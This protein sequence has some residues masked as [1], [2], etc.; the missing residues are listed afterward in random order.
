MTNV[1][2]A[3]ALALTWFIAAGCSSSAGMSDESKPPMVSSTQP[4]QS[5][6]TL[7]HAQNPPVAIERVSVTLNWS[8]GGGGYIQADPALLACDMPQAGV[9]S[10][11]FPKGVSVRL[12]AEPIDGADFLG[13]GGDCAMAGSST[14]CQLTIEGT[15]AIDVIFR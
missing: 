7:A 9:Q 11:T 5:T 4:I 15:T 3:R 12:S 6:T 8:G 10:C 13:W 14:T 2:K 1:H